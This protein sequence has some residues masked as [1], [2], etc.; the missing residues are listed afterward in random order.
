MWDQRRNG[1]MPNHCWETPYSCLQGSKGLATAAR[2][3]FQLKLGVT[4]RGKEPW[5][6]PSEWLGSNPTPQGPLSHHSAAFNNSIRTNRTGS[7]GV[8]QTSVFKVR[9]T[10]QRGQMRNEGKG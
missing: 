1:E 3:V 8:L 6:G 9:Q 10:S 7:S 2:L 4:C 5:G